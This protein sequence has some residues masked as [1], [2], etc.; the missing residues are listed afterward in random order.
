M[1][2]MV[3]L[4]V[5]IFEDHNLDKIHYTSKENHQEI[6]LLVVQKAMK[7]DLFWCIVCGN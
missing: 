3:R 2:G 4:V 7:S 5:V 1:K 6:E